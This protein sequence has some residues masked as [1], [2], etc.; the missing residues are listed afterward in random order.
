MLC[1]ILVHSHI[2]EIS[3]TVR[4]DQ[5][6]IKALSLWHYYLI[7]N[8]IYRLF[9]R[10][11]SVFEHTLTSWQRNLCQCQRNARTHQDDTCFLYTLLVLI[12]IAKK[13]EQINIFTPAP[14]GVALCPGMTIHSNSTTRYI[15]RPTSF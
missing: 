11:V 10:Q 2:F 15:S 3:A 13:S 8:F 1:K 6:Q 5:P 4:Y 9:S 7:F 14:Q 12:K